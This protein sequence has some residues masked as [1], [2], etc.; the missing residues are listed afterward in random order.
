M[1]S[2]IMLTIADDNFAG[3]AWETLP[4]RVQQHAEPWMKFLHEFAD[5][6]EN[7]W[8]K[9]N[10]GNLPHFVN[11]VLWLIPLAR[12][13][14]QRTELH[15]LYPLVHHA[16]IEIKLLPHSTPQHERFTFYAE[17]DGVFSLSFAVREFSP[18]TWKIQELE[19]GSAEQLVQRLIEVVQTRTLPP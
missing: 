1:E 5:I 17:A 2:F 9:N 8:D 4:E 3:D 7:V 11:H 16:V 19:T 13:L 14:T 18:G 6:D 12:V 15:G 10:E